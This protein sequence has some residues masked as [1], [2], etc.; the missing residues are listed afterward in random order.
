MKALPT[1]P[2]VENTAPVIAVRRI[3]TLSLSIL[4]TV[5]IKNVTPVHVEPTNAEIRTNNTFKQT[6]RRRIG[7]HISY[8]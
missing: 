6:D 3:P 2:M 4:D 5:H 7:F 8:H 1:R